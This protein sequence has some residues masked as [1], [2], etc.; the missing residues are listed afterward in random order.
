MISKFAHDQNLHRHTPVCCGE[1][2]QLD[3][4][5]GGLIVGYVEQN[6]SGIG[7]RAHRSDENS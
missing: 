5:A 3:Y 7:H 4:K 1:H 2:V 6:L